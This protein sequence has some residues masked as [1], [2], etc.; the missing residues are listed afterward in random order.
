MIG[1][2]GLIEQEDEFL[3]EVAEIAYGALL[4]QGLRRSFLEVELEVWHAIRAS[5][6]ARLPGSAALAE[7]AG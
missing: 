6:A 3:A 7:V 5:Y 4:K 1:F 2:D